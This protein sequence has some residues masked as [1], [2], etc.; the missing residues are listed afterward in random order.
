MTDGRLLRGQRTRDAILDTAVALASVDGLDGLSLGRLA[1]ELGVSKSG[2]FAHWRDKEQLQLDAVERAVRMWTDL[3]VRPGLQA[4]RGVR[5]VFALHEQRLKFYADGV[6]PG[7][8]FFVA[9]QTEFDD[10]PGPVRDAVKEAKRGWSELIESVVS[11]AI[12]CGELVPETSP[13]QLAFEIGAIGEAVVIESRLVGGRDAVF[14]YA[15]RA[16]LD[17]LRSLCPDPSLLPEA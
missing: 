7:G 12:A 4:P 14:G 1:G 13:P 15:R 6:L 16:V 8:C 10:R 11:D 2:L 5:R 17:R 3:I 9:A